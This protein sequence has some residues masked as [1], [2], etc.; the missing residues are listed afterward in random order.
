MNLPVAQ[1]HQ[2]DLL[3]GNC[4]P[5]FTRPGRPPSPEG[6][7]WQVRKASFSV[8]LKPFRFKYFLY[9]SVCTAHLFPSPMSFRRP[10]VRLPLRFHG[11]SSRNI[12][13]TVIHPFLKSVKAGSSLRLRLSARCMFLHHVRLARLLSNRTLCHTIP[14]RQCHRCNQYEWKLFRW[15]SRAKSVI[16]PCVQICGTASSLTVSSGR[17][18]NTVLA[19]QIPESSFS[20]HK[21]AFM[22]QLFCRHLTQQKYT[23]VRSVMHARVSILSLVTTRSVPRQP[24]MQN[25]SIGPQNQQC[26]AKD[27]KV[28][29]GRVGHVPTWHTDPQPRNSRNWR[30]RL[31]QTVSRPEGGEQPA[32][33]SNQPFLPAARPGATNRATDPSTTGSNRP[34]VD[35]SFKPEEWIQVKLAKKCIR[36]RLGFIDT[37]RGREKSTLRKSL[38]TRR[39]IQSG[40]GRSFFSFRIILGAVLSTSH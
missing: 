21:S 4:Q 38:S 27:R 8:W 9:F 16:F 22:D 2:R 25:W 10:T 12:P 15:I 14:N 39:W 19:Y 24:A 32:P 6:A 35:C 31:R 11:H 5:G 7:G 13:F 1:D 29:R 37:E 28:L 17:F 26:M 18:A 34:A 33:T 36:S 3:S 40:S 30:A 23:T 20:A